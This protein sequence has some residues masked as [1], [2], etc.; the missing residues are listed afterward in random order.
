MKWSEEQCPCTATLRVR[1]RCGRALV[2]CL[3]GRR[4]GLRVPARPPLLPLPLPVPLHLCALTGVRRRWILAL[5][6]H[7]G[8]REVRGDR[9]TNKTKNKKRKK[10]KKKAPHVSTPP[11][12]PRNQSTRSSTHN[13]KFK[14]KTTVT[15][16]AS[17]SHTHRCIH[18]RVTSREKKASQKR[19]PLPRLGAQVGRGCCAMLESD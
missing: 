5:L 8:Q 10:N 3:R 11:A 1:V 12:E 9:R 6:T 14:S 13:N 18:Q 17:S 15:Q 16:Q 4:T 19:R 2:A 7:R